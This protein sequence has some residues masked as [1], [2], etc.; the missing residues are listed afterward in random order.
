MLLKSRH[1]FLNGWGGFSGES[2]KEARKSADDRGTEAA[3][4]QI[5]PG[6]AEIRE[7]LRGL[8]ERGIGIREGLNSR[9]E[10]TE[11]RK[12]SSECFH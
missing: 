3:L 11:R 6:L 2:L 12:E 8:T 7:R 9:K 4:A 5:Y 1:T 10:T